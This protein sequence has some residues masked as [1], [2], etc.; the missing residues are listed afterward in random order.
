MLR[1][2]ARAPLKRGVPELLTKSQHTLFGAT[3]E[4]AIGHRD[5]CHTT[6]PLTQMVAF[7]IVGK[8]IGEALSGHSE[9]VRQSPEAAVSHLVEVPDEHS[10]REGHSG[11]GS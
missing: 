8:K 5:N 3:H 7:P 1:L 2:Q 10:I 11:S 4:C 9:L 6:V